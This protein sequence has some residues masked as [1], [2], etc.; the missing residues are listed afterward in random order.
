MADFIDGLTL[1]L[2]TMVAV[3]QFSG[4]RPSIDLEPDE[5]HLDPDDQV[6]IVRVRNSTPFAVQIRKHRDL[7]SSS[8]LI[9]PADVE[10]MAEQM[11]SGTVNFW[12]EAGAQVELH[13]RVETGKPLVMLLD[14]RRLGGLHLTS[15]IPLCIVMSSSA[16][17][18]L[19]KTQ[20]KVEP[21][22]I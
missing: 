3:V 20:K 15:L 16:L 18:R 21:L 7:L 5:R 22:R 8:R 12:V 10:D 6:F 11:T 13:L 17:A 4:N 9:A 1:T 2:A 14:W 19:K